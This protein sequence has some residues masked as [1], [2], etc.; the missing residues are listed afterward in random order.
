MCGVWPEKRRSA[1]RE[2]GEEEKRAKEKFRYAKIS[3]SEMR[4]REKRERKAEIPRNKISGS[5]KIAYLLPWNR[6]SEK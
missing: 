5:E 2:T 1:E 4:R 6:H 3:G